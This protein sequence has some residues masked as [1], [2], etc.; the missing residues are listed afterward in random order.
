VE[1]IT[2]RLQQYANELPTTKMLTIDEFAE[3]VALCFLRELRDAAW[4]AEP[5]DTQLVIA[6]AMGMTHAC[7]QTIATENPRFPLPITKEMVN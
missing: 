1:Q 5:P 6:T 2:G 4:L 7:M 3:R